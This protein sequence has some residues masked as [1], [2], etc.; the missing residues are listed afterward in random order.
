MET[1]QQRPKLW[2]VGSNPTWRTKGVAH[3]KKSF[4]CF[5]TLENGTVKDTLTKKLDDLRAQ[6]CSIFGI[7]EYDKVSNTPGHRWV[8][9]FFREK[10]EEIR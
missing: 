6:G 9:I 1:E 5:K 4:V 3:M 7:N 2:V 8:D 10:G